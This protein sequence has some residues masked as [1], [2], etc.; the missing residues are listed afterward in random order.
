MQVAPRA[1]V[2]DIDTGLSVM[3]ADTRKLTDITSSDLAQR[4]ND[5]TLEKRWSEACVSVHR[6]PEF[7]ALANNVQDE[8]LS[9]LLGRCWAGQLEGR[10][11]LYYSIFL[12]F[13]CRVG[14]FSGSMTWL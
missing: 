1:E 11:D 12:A 3:Q 7:L 2:S 5:G 4:S 6:H 14:P 9:S 13:V 10:R 8:M